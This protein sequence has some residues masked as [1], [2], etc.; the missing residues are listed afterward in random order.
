M[1]ETLISQIQSGGDPTKIASQIEGILY[2]RVGVI[3]EQ[4]RLQEAASI[5]DEDTGHRLGQ[6]MKKYGYNKASESK[7]HSVKSGKEIGKTVCYE[8][9]DGPS[10]KLHSA[11][12]NWTHYNDSKP[13]KQGSGVDELK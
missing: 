12:D 8:H 5:L 9:P 11:W 1:I 3:L 6:L 4:V 7:D 2:A 10:L 13:T